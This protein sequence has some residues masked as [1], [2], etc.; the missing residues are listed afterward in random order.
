MQQ[1]SGIFY[2][3]FSK[4]SPNPL[5]KMNLI[6]YNKMNSFMFREKSHGN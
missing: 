1:I 5:F 4:N 2:A 3:K 6:W